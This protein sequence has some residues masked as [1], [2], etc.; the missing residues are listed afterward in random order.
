MQNEKAYPLSTQSIYHDSAWKFV[1][2][3]VV[4][5]LLVYLGLILFVPVYPATLNNAQTI[6]SYGHYLGL[7]AFAVFLFF[8]PAKVSRAKY[9]PVASIF[10]MVSL[11]C[12]FLGE[13]ILNMIKMEWGLG[14]A[15]VNFGRNIGQNVYTFALQIFFFLLALGIRKFANYL[16]DI[17]KFD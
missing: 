8:I 2:R 13:F 5:Y 6:F 10:F 11:V 7:L 12:F 9:L 3:I 17:N 14:Q 1:R 4:Y 15:L 16:V